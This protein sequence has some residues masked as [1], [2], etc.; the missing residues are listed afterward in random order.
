VP[1]E[2]RLLA[3]LLAGRALAP[4]VLLDRVMTTVRDFTVNVEQHD[5]IT[6]L[7]LRY[8]NIAAGVLN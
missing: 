8:E 2:D 4:A 6:A 3:E 5:D 1:G 7:I